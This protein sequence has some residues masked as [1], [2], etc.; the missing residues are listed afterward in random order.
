MLQVE[1][2]AK[3]PLQVVSPKE[4]LQRWVPWAEKGLGLGN[5]SF[6]ILLHS[7]FLCP[8]GA[9]GF[10]ALQTPQLYLPVT[11][12]TPEPCPL[13]ILTRSPGPFLSL[14]AH[15]LSFHTFP[16]L[17]GSFTWT[18]RRATC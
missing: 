4:M 18:S 9:S 11:V 12:P 16:S 8:P 2:A 13:A 7:L 14:H 1:A 15:A 5:Y 10:L 3:K 6:S 17:G